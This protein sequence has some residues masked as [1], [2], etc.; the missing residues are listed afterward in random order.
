MQNQMNS[1]ILLSL[2][3]L[4][5][6]LSSCKSRFQIQTYSLNRKIKFCD[7]CEQRKVWS[8]NPIKS[9][10][11]IS[12]STLNYI[13]SYGGIGTSKKIKY[14]ISN[15]TLNIDKIDV[16]GQNLTERN[17]D[18]SR[19]YLINKDSLVSLENDEKYYSNSYQKNKP[20]KI[21]SFYIV[22]GNRE[23][24]IDNK[25][26]AIRELKKLIKKE[27]ELIELDVKIAKSKYGISE[28]YKTYKVNE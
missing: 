6:I 11:L 17:S 2:L 12:D 20:K 15:D 4:I 8:S 16:Y 25:R 9:I 10:V 27:R 23:I 18:F 3:T 22:I 26:K 5:G 14:N 28:I 21:A 7:A 24:K 19:Q 13:K 1:K